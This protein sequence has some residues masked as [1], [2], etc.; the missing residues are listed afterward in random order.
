MKRMHE[1]LRRDKGIA[2]EPSVVIGEP[3]Y[4]SIKNK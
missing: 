4:L 3:S 1:K 2:P